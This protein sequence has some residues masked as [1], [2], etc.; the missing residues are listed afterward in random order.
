MHQFNV[1]IWVG[2]ALLLAACAGKEPTAVPPLN[3]ADAH[4]LIEQSLPRNVPDRAG[5]ADDMYS[6]FTVLTVTPNRENICAVTA[7]IE[8]DLSESAPR[9]GGRKTAGSA[10]HAG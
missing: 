3:P 9:G 2:I 7:V 5:W 10:K 6:A 4:A 8:Q 1:P